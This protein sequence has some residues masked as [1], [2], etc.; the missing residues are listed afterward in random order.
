VGFFDEWDGKVSFLDGSFSFIQSDI[1]IPSYSLGYCWFISIPPQSLPLS[2]TNH[3]SRLPVSASVSALSSKLWHACLGHLAIRSIN[4]SIKSHCV[5]EL[6]SKMISSFSR[7]CHSCSLAKSQHC[8]VQSPS[9]EFVLK[10]GDVVAIDLVGPF[11]EAI[12]G[13]LYGLIIHNFF[14]CMNLFYGVKTK[15]EA[16][17]R[18]MSWVGNFEKH[19]SYSVMC[20]RSNNAGEFTS[21]RFNTFLSE[22]H[23]WH[24]MSIPYEHHQNGSVEQTNWSLLDMACTFMVHAR[25][26][27]TLWPLAMKQATFIFNWIAHKGETKTPYEICMGTKPS[28]EMVRVSGCQAYFHN[29]NYPKQF[30]DRAKSMIHVGVSDVNHGWVLWDPD[31]N[32]LKRGASIVFD[33]AVFPQNSSDSDVLESV[34]SSIW[35]N[36]LGDFS[37]IRDLQI[38]DS[39]LDSMLAVSSFMSDAPNTYRQAQLLD[40][41]DDWMEACKAEIDMM[42]GLQ[43][44]EEVPNAPDLEVLTCQWV[45]ALK[46][47]QEGQIVKFKARIVEQGFKQVHGVNVTETFSPTPTFLSLRLLLAMASNFRWLVASFDVKSAFLCSDIDHEIYI[48]PPPGVNVTDGSVLKLWKALY[49]TQQASCCWWLHL[50]TKLAT[51]GFFP[52]LED[53]LTYAYVLGD[54]QAFLWVHVDDG[55]FTTSSPSLLATLRKHLNSVLDLKWGEQLASIVGLRVREVKGG[56]LVNQ[57]MLIQKILGLSPSAIK[58]RTPIASTDLVSNPL[59]EMDKDYL[60]R[61]GC[62]LYLLQGLRPDITFLVNFLARFSMAPDASHWAA[63]EHLISYIRFT[64]HLSLPII[65]KSASPVSNCLTT[66]V[67][68]NW[69]GKAARS[70]HRFFSFAWG[71]PVSWSSK[72]QSCVARLTCQAEYMALSFA[73]KGAFF[74]QSLVSKFIPIQPPLI[75]SDSK[76]EVH[77]SSDCGTRKEHWHINC[78]FHVINKLLFREKFCLEWVSTNQQMAN[79]FTKALGWRK[80]SEFLDQTGLRALSHM[81]AS[82]G[83]KVCAGCEK[84]T[85]PAIFRLSPGFIQDTS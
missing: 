42:T 27:G 51:I 81:L 30:V 37:H 46:R 74:L 19:T 77:I 3:S 79:I 44:W 20:I 22:N 56:F 28:L 80:V 11:P 71:A 83:G 43:V 10:P 23:I 85:P 35:V 7:K 61:I 76:A 21:N 63:V 59:G 41:W 4:R 57:P 70:V 39:C 33:E 53:Q 12:E 29:L 54:D 47:N 60:S 48:W 5:N 66:Y 24:E 40:D 52:N 34:L 55:L 17:T 36:H 45:F 25:V 78:E 8:P 75:L 15:A 64:S 72:Q 68:A 16:P 62:L 50:K 18:V 69:G 84:H 58:T 26:P 38:Q 73:L 9:Q 1:V 82:I 6:P 13:S 31:L 14:S 49:G 2:P 65:A 32:E 67:D